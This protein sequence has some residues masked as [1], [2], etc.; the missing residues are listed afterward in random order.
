MAA[1]F[2]KEL[3]GYFTSITGFLFLAF[4][5][6]AVGIYFAAYNLYYAYPYFS[7][8]LSASVFIFLIAVPVLS[9]RILAEERHQKTD[10]LLFTSPKGLTAIVLGKYGAL[11]SVLLAAV[12]VFCG[13]PF[14]LSQFGKV[15]LPMAFT[16]ILGF[17]LLGASCLAVG[18]FLSSLTES[19]VIAAVLTFLVLF[20]SF[21]LSSLETF[22]SPSALTSLIGIAGIIFV[23]F[24]IYFF[25]TKN[26]VV[27]VAGGIIAEFALNLLYALNSSIFENLLDK[28]FSAVD[29]FA[30]YNNMANGILDLTEIVYFISVIILFLFLTVQSLQKRRW[31]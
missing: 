6:A 11:L 20:L 29:L 21:M 9:M 7:Y 27:A 13:Y 14:I 23:L 3:R 25:L 17:F 8:T 4:L 10:Q 12:L 22:I 1:V 5:M 24:C 15:N 26:A 16:A 31:S 18:M 19:Q 2:K 28:I 30:H